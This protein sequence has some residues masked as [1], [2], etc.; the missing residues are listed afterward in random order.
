MTVLGALLSSEP[1]PCSEE[2]VSSDCSVFPD[3]SDWS[4]C[5]LVSA[6]RKSSFGVS[7]GVS[8]AD[9]WE[10]EAVCAVLSDVTASV[11]SPVSAFSEILIVPMIPSEGAL[12]DGF[13]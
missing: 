12:T 1:P 3:N 11:V 7:S 10:M 13:L 9:I 5:V 2:S 6:V 4:V 8:F